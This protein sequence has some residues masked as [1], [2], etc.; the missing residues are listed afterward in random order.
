MTNKIKPHFCIIANS[1]YGLYFGEVLN[2]D[3]K[4]KTV[5]VKNCRHIARWYGGTGGITSLAAWGPKGESRIGAP[6]DALLTSVVNLFECT[7]EAV[8]AFGVMVPTR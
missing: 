8:K 7:D 4:E 1:N 5:S 3:V 6:C 2:H